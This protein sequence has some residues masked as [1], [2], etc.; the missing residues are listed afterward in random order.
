MKGYNLLSK[1]IILV[2]QFLS[3]GNALNSKKFTSVKAGNWFS[4]GLLPKFFSTKIPE[5]DSSCLINNKTSFSPIEAEINSS[6]INPNLDSRIIGNLEVNCVLGSTGLSSPYGTQE[7]CGFISWILNKCINSWIPEL[8]RISHNFLS[9]YYDQLLALGFLL[10]VIS[11]ILI[12]YLVN[13]M[14]PLCVKIYFGLIKDMNNLTVV[15]GELSKKIKKLLNIMESKK[16]EEQLLEKGNKW[17]SRLLLTSNVIYSFVYITTLFI[18]LVKYN[19]IAFL[20]KIALNWEISISECD[21]NV[22]NIINSNKMLLIKAY[23]IILT[24]LT[25]SLLFYVKIKTIGIIKWGTLFTLGSLL[26]SIIFL[27]I[28]FFFKVGL[29]SLIISV[30]IDFI[31]IITPLFIEISQLIISFPIFKIGIKGVVNSIR[32]YYYNRFYTYSGMSGKFKSLKYKYAA[33]IIGTG[34][35]LE[36]ESG[37]GP[38]DTSVTEEDPNKVNDSNTDINNMNE[39]TQNSTSNNGPPI[40]EAK[41]EY[42]INMVNI[43]DDTHMQWVYDDFKSTVIGDVK[44]QYSYPYLSI[45]RLLLSNEPIPINAYTLLYKVYVDD[46]GVRQNLVSLFPVLREI[47]HSYIYDNNWALSMR[48][49]EQFKPG[50]LKLLKYSI[51]SGQLEENIKSFPTYVYEMATLRYVVCDSLLKISTYD[52]SILNRLYLKKREFANILREL[53]EE[54]DG[55]LGWFLDYVRIDKNFKNNE[56]ALDLANYLGDFFREMSGLKERY[57]RQVINLIVDTKTVTRQMIEN[58]ERANIR[59]ARSRVKIPGIKDLLDITSEMS[60]EPENS[61]SSSTNDTVSFP[62]SSQDVNFN[63]RHSIVPNP[64]SVKAGVPRSSTPY[65]NSDVPRFNTV[66]PNNNVP[67]SD[68]PVPSTSYFEPDYINFNTVYY[69]TIPYELKDSFFNTNV[70]KTNTYNPSDNVP[71]AVYANPGVSSPNTTYPYTGVLRPNTPHFPV[72]SES[73]S[74]P[75]RF[76]SSSNDGSTSL[77]NNRPDLSFN[78]ESVSRSKEESRINQFGKRNRENAENLQGKSKIKRRKSS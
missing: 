14:I 16:K 1:H 18:I 69:N 32:G 28:F 44:F 13:K 50:Y 74:I 45:L 55:I 38:S 42:Y 25:L 22:E 78:D 4:W 40:D 77:F 5:K 34:S 19:E 20:I 60:P 48:Q 21:L 26:C 10:I 36:S 30:L 65:L 2:L 72:N 57:R 12:H 67:R 54:I 41:S 46:Q 56:Q 51:E 11:F 6:I 29:L 15:E 35:N 9:V 47:M 33:G 27:F 39:N 52:Q 37:D 66:N 58:E 8:Y 49:F 63:F 73:V 76:V 17:T 31:P 75:N 53:N 62:F 24:P 59:A 61:S 64:S 3:N 43:M 71:N 70:P 68:T 23:K 7:L